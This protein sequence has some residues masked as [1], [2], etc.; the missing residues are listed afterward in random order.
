MKVFILTTHLEMGGISI[1]VVDLARALKRRGHEPIV[2]SSGGM[3]ERRLAEE[4]IRHIRIP[5]RTSSELNPKLWL[6]AFPRLLKIFRQERPDLVHVHT[7]VTQALAWALSTV[8]GIPY[9]TTCHGLY[10]FRWGR[11]V[12]RCWGSWV[13]AISEA[14]MERLVRQ[15]RLAPPHQVVLVEN[16]VDVNRFQQPADPQQVEHFRQAHGLNGG[17][18]IG[19]IARLS[20]VKGLDLLLKAMPT[21]LKEF[22]G[23]QLLLVGDGPARESLVRLAYELGIADRVVIS[24]SV[25]DTRVPLSLLQVFVAPAWREGFGL[26][27]VEAMAAGVPVVSSSA[28][29]PAE[30]L[31]QGKSGLLVPP[32]DVQAVENAVRILLKDPTAR[33]QIAERAQRRAAERYDFKRVATQVE[34]VYARTLNGHAR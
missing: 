34:E 16:G 17:P 25:E 20:P 29:G 4:G 3:L 7:R 19:A 22:P 9:V 1:Y 23:L 6:T 28:G 31:E 13:M 21:L 8:T 12:F 27:I 32:G 30:I 10:R 18:V 33:R 24:S 26:A 15:Y 2:F 5:C 14:S 11:R